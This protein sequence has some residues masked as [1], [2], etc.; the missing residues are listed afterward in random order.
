MPFRSGSEEKHKQ[1]SCKVTSRPRA[2]PEALA[3]LTVLLIG[4]SIQGRQW[5]CPAQVTQADG[6]FSNNLIEPSGSTEAQER[7]LHQRAFYLMSLKDG[8]IQWLCHLH[9]I[10]AGKLEIGNI[11]PQQ[12]SIGLPVPMLSML[13]QTYGY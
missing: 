10:S 4:S 9:N 8:A 1:F 11:G 12:L 6:S 13:G 5:P 2:S 3:L 7:S